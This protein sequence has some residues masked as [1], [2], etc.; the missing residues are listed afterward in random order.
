VGCGRASPGV[1]ARPT[2]THTH[3][4]APAH[5]L[6][7]QFIFV[8][9]DN[10]TKKKKRKRRRNQESSQR[11]NTTIVRVPPID[12][13]KKTLK[14]KKE[15]RWYFFETVRGRE[16]GQITKKHEQ[17]AAQK[18]KRKPTHVHA[19]THA[20]GHVES[21][22]GKTKEETT[23]QKR[24]EPSSQDFETNQKKKENMVIFLPSYLPSHRLR[25]VAATGPSEQQKT[26]NT[27]PNVNDK[28]PQPQ[29]FVCWV[30]L[31]RSSV[32]CSSY[33]E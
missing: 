14:N 18:H 7:P 4:R 30:V 24:S 8:L 15:S 19:R 31:I 1:G 3:T 21:R 16:S 27:S 26:L 6:L 29:H 10:N 5:P 22:E 20:C 25:G 17:S 23:V 32:H 9:P 28:H 2:L 12:Q 33:K 13:R 11:T